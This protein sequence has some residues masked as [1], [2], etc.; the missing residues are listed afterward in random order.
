MKPGCP[1]AKKRED[2]LLP[3]LQ[4]KELFLRYYWFRFL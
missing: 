4:E 3:W 1:S 2:E